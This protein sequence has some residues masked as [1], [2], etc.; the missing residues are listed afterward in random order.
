M[1]VDNKD[2][3]V[4]IAKAERIIDAM[5]KDYMLSGFSFHQYYIDKEKGIIISHLGNSKKDLEIRFVP[6]M[7]RIEVYINGKLNNVKLIK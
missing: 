5:T 1:D 2:F 3:K 6:S 7:T 4:L